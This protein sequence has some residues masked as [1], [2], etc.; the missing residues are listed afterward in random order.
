MHS[1][2]AFACPVC[3]PHM[4]AF[5]RF[6]DGELW[7]VDEVFA[8]VRRL[9]DDISTSRC[10]VP[11]E[12]VILPVAIRLL[13]RDDLEKAVRASLNTWVNSLGPAVFGG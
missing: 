3:H 9:V 7:T 4:A 2:A 12:H 13:L 5:Q 1:D 10:G 11:P 6:L 8:A